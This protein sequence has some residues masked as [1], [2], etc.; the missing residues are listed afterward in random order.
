MKGMPILG[1]T[2]YVHKNLV[3]KITEFKSSSERLSLLTIK[4]KNKH[5]TFVNCHA[6]INYDKKN[7]SKVE[8]F[9]EL[10]EDEISKIPKS[11]VVIL[12]GDFNAQTGR[13]KL[14]KK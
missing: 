5:Y 1:T 14:F 12:L 8:A 7:L 2:F 9:W 10:L 4:V 6:P 11:N 13:E 3:D